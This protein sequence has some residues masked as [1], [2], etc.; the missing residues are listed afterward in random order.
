MLLTI[1]TINF[2]N[3]DGLRETIKSVLS[4][5]SI[6]IDNFESS[7]DEDMKVDEIEAKIRKLTVEKSL[8]A[9]RTLV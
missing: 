6:A 5:D 1:I 4:Q 9:E 3:K 7:D 8:S 2:N